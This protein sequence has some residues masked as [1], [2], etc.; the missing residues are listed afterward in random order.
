M[1]KKRDREKDRERDRKNGRKADD[2]SLVV[3]VRPYS[4]TFLVPIT[5]HRQ[6]HGTHKRRLL[7]ERERQREK[8]GTD[9]DKERGQ[10]LGL[11][12]DETSALLYKVYKPQIDF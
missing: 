11:V 3:V 5:Y 12:L 7:G 10:Q 2:A 6:G 8:K 1:I 4:W 9:R